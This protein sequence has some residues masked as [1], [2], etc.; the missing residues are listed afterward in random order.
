MYSG[1]IYTEDYGRLLD[2]YYRSAPAAV[3]RDALK[4]ADMWKMD[5]VKTMAIRKLLDTKLKTVERITLCERDD[6]ERWLARAA[7]L[8]I[9]TRTEPLT[10]AEF[11]ALGMDLGLR[12]VQIRERIIASRN[13]EGQSEGDIVDDV[14]GREPMVPSIAV[15]SYF[16]D[17]DTSD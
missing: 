4:L 10:S 16:Y 3:W 13:G 11:Q 2:E 15:K 6:V 5:R 14:I 1:R 8:K 17:G 7:Y 12:I 9:C